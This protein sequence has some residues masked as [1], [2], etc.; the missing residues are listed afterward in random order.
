MSA[1]RVLALLAPFVVGCAIEDPVYLDLSS[2]YPLA[3]VEDDVPHLPMVLRA[4]RPEHRD[5]DVFYVFDVIRTEGD[6]AARCPALRLRDHCETHGCTAIPEARVCL[7][8]PRARIEAIAAERDPDTITVGSFVEGTPEILADAP[9]GEVVV[10]LAIVL[11]GDDGT[12][13]CDVPGTTPSF[14][15][16]Q[17]LGCGYS[18]PTLL[19][20]EPSVV[21]IDLDPLTAGV[22]CNAAFVEEC[23]ALGL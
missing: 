8:I 11:A 22:A 14:A 3:C 18:C 17:L 5:E 12:T 6:V 2:R 15:P 9:D 16:D 21:P 1:L 10:R 20:G 23:T 4:F 19:G 13:P 7:R